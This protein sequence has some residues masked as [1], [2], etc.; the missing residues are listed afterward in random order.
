MDQLKIN[1]ETNIKAGFKKTGIAPLDVDETLSRLPMEN[2]CERE[3]VDESFIKYLKE[4]SF[5]TMEIKQPKTKR[6]LEVVVGRSV[7]G[8]DAEKAEMVPAKKKPKL[9]TVKQE[10]GKEKG[11]GKKTKQ[12]SGEPYGNTTIKY[13][14]MQVS[15]EKG[16]TQKDLN[17]DNGFETQEIEVEAVDIAEMPMYFSDTFEYNNEPSTSEMPIFFADNLNCT[18]KPPKVKIISNIKLPLPL[19]NKKPC[20][21]NNDYNEAE[22][23][24][25]VLED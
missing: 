12:N 10:K 25:K 7:S 20:Q 18:D 19:K 23:I 6:K 4:L 15:P 1:S 24:L 11:I 3:V 8:E 16:F 5:G 13:D 2:D 22:A 21:V 14:D 9:K 17:S